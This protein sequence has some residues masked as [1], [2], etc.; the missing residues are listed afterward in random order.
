EPGRGPWGA[1]RMQ[2]LLRRTGLRRIAQCA[3]TAILVADHVTVGPFAP[4]SQVAFLN[5]MNRVGR[6]R[7]FAPAPASTK[8]LPRVPRAWGRMRPMARGASMATVDGIDLLVVHLPPGAQDLRHRHLDLLSD[9]WENRDPQLVVGDLNERPGQPS[10]KR[11]ADG[12]LHDMAPDTPATY[13]AD[14]PRAR[15]D[16]I[17]GS[18]SLRTVKAWVPDDEIVLAASDHRPLVVELERVEATA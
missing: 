2:M 10:W 7:R 3:S 11:L 6:T 15:I 18:A 4:R 8:R 12:G 5:A 1:W 17:F 9:R 14:K 13:P 16:V